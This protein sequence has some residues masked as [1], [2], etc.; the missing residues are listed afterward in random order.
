VLFI[1]NP[2]ALFIGKLCN[3]G[4]NLV[5]ETGSRS[6]IELVLPKENCVVPVLTMWKML[7]RDAKLIGK[8]NLR[9]SL[10]LSLAQFK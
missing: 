4:S 9:L 3:V 2:Q 1:Y 10:P 8:K 7:C 6:F 5:Q